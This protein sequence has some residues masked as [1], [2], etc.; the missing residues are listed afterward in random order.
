MN[1]TYDFKIDLSV[2]RQTRDA[3]SKVEKCLDAERERLE[4]AVDSVTCDWDGD[5]SY[6][7]REWM[8]YFLEEGNL[9]KSIEL[10]KSMRQFLE[11]TEPQI[12]KLSVRCGHFA[13][14]LMSDTYEEPFEG[15]GCCMSGAN[16]G[17]ISLNYNMAEIV[18]NLCSGYKEF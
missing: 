9:W 17:V 7:T 18:L 3:Y 10:I 15:S 14:Q 6:A 1:N 12:S 13:Q 8:R 16:G 2:W 4:E 5:A 11:E